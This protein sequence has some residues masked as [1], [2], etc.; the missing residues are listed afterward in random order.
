MIDIDA[1]QINFDQD[2][3]LVLNL[4]LAFIMFGVAM[5]LK[6]DNFRA[7]ASRPKAAIVGLSSQWL[8]LPVLTML[9]IYVA[10]PAPSIAMGMALIACCPGGNVSNFAVHISGANTALSVFMTSI[11]TLAAVVI[12]P[13]VF[14]W[15]ITLIPGTETLRQ[16]IQ[17]NPWEMVETII[18]LILL[19]LAAGMLFQAYLP[20]VANRIKGW[21]RNLSMII[22]FSFV[23]FAIRANF[24]NIV[25]YTH[26]VFFLVLFH[27][28]L[29]L[30]MGY[31]WAKLN[32]LPRNDARAISIETG[33]QN[34]GLGLVLI[35]N[36][37]NGL[38]GMALIAA[39][40]GIWHLISGF[41]I[42][43][44]WQKRSI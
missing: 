36:F 30:L 2:K 27:N 15:L 44:L 19:P 6:V 5:D 18:K 20:Q 26:I 39:W 28:A 8:L 10:Q 21:V 13:L 41:S 33:I 34:S 40:W 3:L 29:A 23:I 7:L 43:M 14:A 12:T 11:S 37:F 1:I 25:R 32:Q 38:G 4:C 24:D 31:G 17:V 16:A 9:L 35:F 22:F 42:A